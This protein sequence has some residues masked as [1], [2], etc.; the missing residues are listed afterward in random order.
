[1]RTTWKVQQHAKVHGGGV[2]Y[3]I[4]SPNEFHV[5]DVGGVT[6]DKVDGLTLDGYPYSI[7]YG[8]TGFSIAVDTTVQHPSARS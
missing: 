5:V 4:D 8:T 7:T 3:W 2:T 6:I 1:M